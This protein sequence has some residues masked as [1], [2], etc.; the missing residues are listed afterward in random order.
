M[1]H[2]DKDIDAKKKQKKDKNIEA[3]FSYTNEQPIVN[4]TI[5]NISLNENHSFQL[6]Y[7][8][9]GNVYY[10]DTYETRS[11][12]IESLRNKF[13]TEGM[14]VPKIYG[15]MKTQIIENKNNPEFISD[16]ISNL[17]SSLTSHYDFTH[18]HKNVGNSGEEMLENILKTP[19]NQPIDGFVC[20]GI[21]E[22][23]MNLLHNCDNNAAIITGFYHG[24]GHATLLYEIEKGKYLYNNYNKNIVIEADNIKDAQRT[25]Y[26]QSPDFESWGHFSLYD[27][28]N[29]FSEYAF[30]DEA[31]FGNKFDKRDYNN[32]NPLNNQYNQESQ[33]YGTFNTSNQNNKRILAGITYVSDN[34]KLHMEN[35]ISLGYNKLGESSLF[36]QSNSVGAKYENKLQFKKFGLYTDANV[37]INQVNGTKPDAIINDKY[38]NITHER[39]CEFLEAFPS[40]S[41]SQF[42]YQPEVV[43]GSTSKYNGILFRGV[44]GKETALHNEDQ[45]NVKNFT[46]TTLTHNDVRR[47]AYYESDAR[48]TAED[49]VQIDLN[50]N[51]TTA[52]LCVG[53]GLVIDPN[54]VVA[55][56]GNPNALQYGSKIN[57]GSSVSTT[58]SPNTRLN[59]QINCYK[60]DMPVSKD[61]G[62]DINASVQYKSQNS[63]ITMFGR[64]GIGFENQEIN[65]GGFQE[66][67]EKRTQLE[68]QLGADIKDKYNVNLGYTR[69]Y[70]NLN[71]TRNNSVISL[72]TNIK[73]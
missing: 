46:Q 44:L 16:Y 15:D 31:V 28:K 5:K 69:L 70:D 1:F 47:N 57:I 33:I 9:M 71:P 61:Y 8:D 2:N 36:A 19:S 30:K 51:N 3:T 20:K 39:I 41:A 45:L 56:N 64:A 60:V 73:L 12:Y 38:N 35:D 62:M 4:G 6:F 42:V 14:P 10:A 21:H 58:V 55:D 13:L 27:E 66:Q 59:S 67:T 17:L 22:F 29:A 48:I 68:L 54:M 65:I 7:N 32:S 34:D 72:N 40:I 37:I 50:K 26:K 24:G 23:A 18:R 53:G 11:P 25:I 52:N 49:H 63:E 43:Q